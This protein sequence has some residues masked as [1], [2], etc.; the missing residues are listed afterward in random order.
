MHVP[1]A[2]VEVLAC[3]LMFNGVPGWRS[4]PNGWTGL[5][6]DRLHD[7][8]SFLRQVIDWLAQLDAGYPANLDNRSGRWRR[9]GCRY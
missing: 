7:E 8:V 6:A 2:A 3:Q 5:D 4:T 1:W 9:I